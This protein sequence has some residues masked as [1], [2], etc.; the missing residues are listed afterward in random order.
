MSKYSWRPVTAW[1]SR[2]S[3]SWLGLPLDMVPVVQRRFFQGFVFERLT[4]GPG[5]RSEEVRIP[6]RRG[7]IFPVGGGKW[8]WCGPGGFWSRRIAGAAGGSASGPFATSATH[9]TRN[10]E[11]VIWFKDGFLEP[12]AT[13]A[14]ARRRRSTWTQARAEEVA[15]SAHPA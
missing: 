4:I 14:G 2:D 6:C 15:L 3:V 9:G 10:D 5:F 13:A 12:V 11:S 8:A 1:P 7:E